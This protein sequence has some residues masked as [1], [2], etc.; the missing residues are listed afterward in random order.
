MTPTEQMNN[1]GNFE[2]PENAT[3]KSKNKVIKRNVKQP[4]AS[5]SSVTSMKKGTGGKK[6]PPSKKAVK[7]KV[8][9]SK[10]GTPNKKVATPLKRQGTSSALSNIITKKLCME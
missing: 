5:T 3:K 7:K 4:T 1:V 2:N 9:T 6:P 10:P 8:V